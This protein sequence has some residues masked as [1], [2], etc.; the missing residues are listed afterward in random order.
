MI[1]HESVVQIS[2]SFTHLT[3][4]AAHS[5]SILLCGLNSSIGTSAGVLSKAE[6]VVRAH[7]D[8]VLHHFACVPERDRERQRWR[9]R[10][11]ILGS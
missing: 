5:D 11:L 9:N 4:S 10:T 3:A 6:V 1:S 7:V 8:D 2:L